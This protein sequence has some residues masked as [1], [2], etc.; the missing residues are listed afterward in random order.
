[1][2]D[3]TV[4][5]G[6]NVAASSDYVSADQTSIVGDGTSA[7]PLHLN[8]EGPVPTAP[9]E[10]VT[11]TIYAR[12]TGS[13][14]T[15]DGSLSSPFRTFQRAIRNVPS[16]IPPGRLFIVDV[17]DLGVETLPS[18]YQMPVVQSTAQ[19]PVANS[20]P[21][22]FVFSAPLTIRAF[23]QPFS[24]VP[25]A[26]TAVPPGAVVSIAT[27]VDNLTTITVS[28]P[29][30][31]WGGDALKGAILTSDLSPAASAAIYGSDPTHLF[32]ANTSDAIPTGSTLS[33]VEQSTTL[34]GPASSAPVENGAV[35]CQDINAIA[36]QGIRF[37][38]TDAN[39]LGIVL[40]NAQRPF[41]ILCDTDGIG[42]DGGIGQQL[43]FFSGVIR[44]KIIDLGGTSFT[45]QR[46]LFLNVSSYLLVGGY[47]VA[48]RTTVLDGCLDALGPKPRFI[49]SGALIQPGWELLNTLSKNSGNT[50]AAIFL[51]AGGNYAFENV[52]I[53][54]SPGDAILAEGPLE[55]QLT[56][57]TGGTG[58]A[59]DPANAGVGVRADDTAVV[60]VRDAATLVT[61]T[62]GDM[63]CGTLPVRSWTSFR[64][65]TP[66]KNEYDLTTPFA[67]NTGSGLSTPAGEETTGPGTGGRSGSRIFQRP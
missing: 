28:T 13:D 67:V 36:W 49:A 35:I 4:R 29:R 43:G 65:S 8:P 45:P 58:G 42:T 50:D 51:Q 10:V 3:T 37:R 27:N 52:R 24:G 34:I 14:A 11:R 66:V 31:S 55:L 23:P 21:S 1:M 6:G 40:S 41:F 25:V 59:G 44:D 53:Q 39:T 33:I 32:V 5:R 60:R 15:G 56:N 47:L 19:I 22:P 38:S 61:G 16:I 20:A 63:K 2:T 46:C 17:T 57:V 54:G 30:A 12:T 64:S 26:D 62:G 9:F 48:F 7:R 18:G